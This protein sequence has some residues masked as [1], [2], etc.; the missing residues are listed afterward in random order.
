MSG[1]ALFDLDNTLIDRDHAFHQWA[2]QFLATR[3]ID[4]V[5]LPWLVSVDGDGKVSRPVFFGALKA[6][7]G[8][9][10][11]EESLVVAY[12]KEAPAFYRPDR[13]ILDALRTLR[14]AGWKTAVITNGPA[15][16]ERKIR[17]AGLEVA[18]DAWCIS[19]VEGV[20]KPAR[21]IFE[22]AATRSGT[23]LKGWMVGDTPEIDIRGWN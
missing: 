6:R 5:E 1:L 7:Y 15:S 14:S 12:Q 10:E 20:A 11:S 13:A 2:V 8:L 22:V 18:L 17:S 4:P 23:S 3:N 16:Q 21:R 19:G 9:P